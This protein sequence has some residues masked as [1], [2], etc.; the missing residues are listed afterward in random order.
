MALI[1]EKQIFVV[2]IL[3]CLNYAKLSKF[4]GFHS[5]PARFWFQPSLGSTHFRPAVAKT[6]VKHSRRPL[7]TTA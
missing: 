4:A 6:C 5:K 3:S 2:I 1:Y 7:N